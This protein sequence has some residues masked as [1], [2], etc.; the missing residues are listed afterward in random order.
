M[1]GIVLVNIPSDG[2]PQPGQRNRSSENF[3]FQTFPTTQLQF[4][5]SENPSVGNIA[6]NVMRDKVLGIDPTIVSGLSNGS[7]V[8]INLFELDADYYI[9]D[10]TGTEGSG[11]VVTITAV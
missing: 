8:P 6:F 11:F 1:S 10:P 4:Q 9:A 5:L 2:A 3:Q 7:T